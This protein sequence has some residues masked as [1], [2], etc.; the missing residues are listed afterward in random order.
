MLAVESIVDLRREIALLRRQGKRIAFVPTMGN[1]HAG[2]LKLAQIARQHADA[3]VASIYVNP[4]QFGP[5]EDLAAYPR[6]PEQDKKGLEAEKTDILF[7]PTDAEMYPRG[8]DVMTKVEVP[9]L[10]DILCGQFRPG[11]FRGVTTVVNRLFNLVQPDV[12]VF[13]KKDYQQLMLIKLMVADLGLPIE[14]VG[15]DTVRE[16]D[17]LAMSSRNNYLSPA[18]RQTAPKLYATLGRLRDRILKEGAVR[19]G[20]EADT[21]REL[22]T[23]GFRPDYI[24]IRRAADL[25]EAGP[26]DKAL[27]ILAAAWLG[28]TRLIDNLEVSVQI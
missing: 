5:K 27:V 8:L 22:E 11:H 9:A 18:E 14:I 25:A 13:G 24:S 3:V 19:P 6:T 20:M 4:L 28:R 16:A 17:G 10:G 15:V 2:H 21:A 7:M 12:A 26:Q 23:A 1:L